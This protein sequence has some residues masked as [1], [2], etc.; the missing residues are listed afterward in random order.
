MPGR[1]DAVE[2]CREEIAAAVAALR[3]AR[4]EEAFGAALD[5]CEAAVRRGLDGAPP[6]AP[7]ACGPGCAGCC[8]LNV[9]T[10]AVEGAAAARY[11]RARLGPG[12]AAVLAHR[13]LAAHDRVRWLEDGERIARHI[14]CALLDDADRCRIHPARP[15]GCRS[16]T[17][18]DAE[19]C[20]R[21]LA[22][23]ADEDEPAVVR[24]D[25]LQRAL[26][27]EARVALADAL[28]RAGL[29]ARFR[30]VSGMT[31]AFLADPGLADAFLAGAR[32]PLE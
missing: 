7:P 11:L 4:G 28:T 15:L 1:D 9:G 13:L 2:R 10:L 14:R 6:R 3:G 27:D 31:G 17:S 8:V 20:R 32:V 16:V 22:G 26:Y 18:L 12:D 21:A 23:A 29:D 30:D 19:D 24:M 5:A 25:L